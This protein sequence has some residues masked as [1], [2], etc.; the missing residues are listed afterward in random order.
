MSRKERLII[1]HQRNVNTKTISLLF[2]ASANMC[3]GKRYGSAQSTNDHM[4]VNVQRCFG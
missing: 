4:C 1:M 3:C 2:T